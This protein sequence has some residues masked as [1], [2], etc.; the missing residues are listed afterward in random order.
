M[1]YILKKNSN[2]L[3]FPN[4]DSGGKSWHLE[5]VQSH[6]SPP[7]HSILCTMFSIHIWKPTHSSIHAP[8][9]ASREK[10]KMIRGR[11]CAAS[12]NDSRRSSRTKS[13]R[14]AK[15]YARYKRQM[16]RER[17]NNNSRRRR[18]MFD[19]PQG[20]RISV[21]ESLF[22]LVVQLWFRAGRTWVF[23]SRYFFGVFNWWIERFWTVVEWYLWCSI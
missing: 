10:Q 12:Q 16:T 8:R 1:T 15:R 14:L 19:L 17:P 11:K 9:M 18:R 2:L 3:K 4:G 7:T 6:C 5:W 21:G 13:S 22:S 23:S 20:D